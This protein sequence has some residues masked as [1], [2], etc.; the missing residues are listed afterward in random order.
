MPVMFIKSD[1]DM[2]VAKQAMDDISRLWNNSREEG[3][4]FLKE[5]SSDEEK[6]NE[7]WKHYYKKRIIGSRVK[8]SEDGWTKNSL[9][10]MLPQK[11]INWM[12]SMLDSWGESSAG[13][14]DTSSLIKTTEAMYE[15]IIGMIKDVVKIIDAYTRLFLDQQLTLLVLP[16]ISG[17]ALNLGSITYK[18]NEDLFQMLAAPDF[19]Y[20]G[21][22]SA[23]E[24]LSEYLITLPDILQTAAKDIETD[25]AIKTGIGYPASKQVEL[26]GEI[27]VANPFNKENIETN[28]VNFLRPDYFVGGWVFVFKGPSIDLVYAQ[29]RAFFSIFGINI[30]EFKTDYSI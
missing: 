1:P 13:A 2:L 30:P 20:S 27:T 9:A 26:F 28:V 23:V 19:D 15:S 10:D 18:Y 12:Q 22:K 4:A 24:L 11:A 25:P 3:K 14:P 7:F 16:P 29:A 5:F 8:V 6:R 21:K 17:E